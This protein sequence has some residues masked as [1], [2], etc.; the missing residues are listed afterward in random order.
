MDH[1]CCVRALYIT[2]ASAIPSK[3]HTEDVIN[4]GNDAKPIPESGYGL[5]S[6]YNARMMKEEN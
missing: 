5:K 3:H 2:F 4:S 6:I 1:D